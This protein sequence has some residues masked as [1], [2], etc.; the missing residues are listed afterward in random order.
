MSG[1]EDGLGEAVADGFTETDEY[2]DDGYGAGAAAPLQPQTGI[3]K[4]M[5][6]YL[7]G[8]P[9]RVPPKRD[10]EP[11]YFMDMLN[12]V[13]IDLRIPQ[14]NLIQTVNGREASYVLE[15]ADGDDIKI[16]WDQGSRIE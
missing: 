7:N 14:G 9:L 16:Q 3:R 10:G 11:Y 2:S 12:Y 13:N 8:N 4:E 1:E 5:L 15:L 6:V